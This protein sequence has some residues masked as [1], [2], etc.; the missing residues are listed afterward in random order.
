MAVISGGNVARGGSFRGFSVLCVCVSGL[1]R[2]GL[3]LDRCAAPYVLLHLRH[4]LPGG[5]VGVVCG[6]HCD[7][8]LNA[9]LTLQVVLAPPV[10][11]KKKQ[12]CT[13]TV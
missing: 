1:T 8:V 13:L 9:A 2:T 10:W 6:A 12:I 4:S 3:D 5:L 7:L 11:R